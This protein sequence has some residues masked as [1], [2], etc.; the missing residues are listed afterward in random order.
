MA[1]P[2]DN[3]ASEHR[4]EPRRRVLLSGK[5]VYGPAELTQDCVISDLSRKGAKVRMRGPEPLIDPIYLIDVRHGLAFKARE[6]WREGA[7]VGLAFTRA[8]DLRNPPPE[9]PRILRRIW[10]EQTR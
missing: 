8:F 5:L 9:A 1:E 6:A 7:L 4:N 3:K 10:V 2:P